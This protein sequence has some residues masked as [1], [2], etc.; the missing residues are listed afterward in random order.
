MKCSICG[1]KKNCLK[2]VCSICNR[3]RMTNEPCWVVCDFCGLSCKTNRWRETV[4]ARKGSYKCRKCCSEDSGKRMKRYKDSLTPEQ[5]REEAIAGR[6]AVKDPSAAVRKQWDT[7]RNDPVLKK[8]KYTKLKKQAV[9]FWENVDEETKNRIIKALTKNRS[10]SLISDKLTQDMKDSGIT[11]FESEQIFHGFIP[12]EIN[13]ELKIIVEMY[14]EVYHCNPR[15]Y[16]DPNLFLKIIGRTVGQQ[17]KRDRI[18]LACFY[19]HG[20]TVIIVWEKDYRNDP[21]KQLERIRDEIA[22]KEKTN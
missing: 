21:K 18:R 15:R 10:R 19:K 13:H 9:D 2:N 3:A 11:G 6:R 14:G 8:K 22:K 5:R 4:I 12:D 7:I 1:K 17:W 20:Y 16:K